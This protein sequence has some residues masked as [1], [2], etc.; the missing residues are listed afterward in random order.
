M[1]DLN[2]KVFVVTG[3]GNGVG[4]SLTL[5]L[6]AK[7]AR[8]AAVDISLPFLKETVRAAKTSA[9]HLKTYVVDIT[10]LEAVNA[11]PALIEKDFG[12][13]DGLI[14]NAGIIQPFIKVM[15][16]KQID[17]DRV[18]NVNFLRNPSYVSRFLTNLG[19]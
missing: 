7:G 3:A 8:V 15:D 10:S 2:N 11:L 12:Q 16:L 4:R 1:K 17:I 9:S 18:M 13:I 5:G 14:N 19:D 6:L